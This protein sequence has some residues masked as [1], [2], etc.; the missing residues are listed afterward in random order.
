MA[1]TLGGSGAGGDRVAMSTNGQAML[2]VGCPAA[3]GATCEGDVVLETSGGVPI[4]QTGFD[5]PPGQTE[6]VP[7]DLPSNV[8]VRV[9]RTGAFRVRARTTI[10]ERLLERSAARRRAPRIVATEDLVLTPDP[11]TARVRDAGRTLRPRNAVVAIRLACPRERTPGCAGRLRALTTGGR[12]LG[13]S[14]F[15]LRAGQARAVRLPLSSAGRRLLRG[16]RRL[17]VVLEVATRQ[18]GSPAIAKR[19]RISLRGGRR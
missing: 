9:E 18:A 5:V 7:V 1:P 3:A 19:I 4:A 15:K 14:T 10:R 17:G 12:A 2:A 13:Q 8:Q 6:T 16:R 11:R